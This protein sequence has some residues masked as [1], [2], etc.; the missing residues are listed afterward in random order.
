MANPRGDESY[1]ALLLID[2]QDDFLSDRGRMPVARNQVSAV[3]AAANAA[4]EQSQAAGDLILKIGNEFRASDVV[5]NAL[6]HHAAIAG[7]PGTKWDPRVDVADATYLVKWKGDAFCNR[8][9]H[10][11]LVENRV[12]GITLAG[13]Y[14]RACITA[15]AKGAMKRGLKVRLLVDAIACR[16]DATRDAAVTRMRRRGVQLVPNQPRKDGRS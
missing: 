4:I 8:E 11:V 6:R 1:G 9:L 15:T 2:F 12:E 14:A 13:V 3:I 16:S 10:Q 7:S 5:R